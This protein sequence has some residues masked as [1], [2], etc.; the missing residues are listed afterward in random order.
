[1]TKPAREL[2][3]NR[4]PDLLVYLGIERHYLTGKH[5]PCPACGG[6]DRFRFDDKDG[7]GTYF[8]SHCGSGDGF[9]LLGLVKGWSFKQAATEVEQIV[10][11]IRATIPIHQPAQ[12]DMKEACRRIWSE[13]TPVVDS[14]PVSRYLRLRTGL[15]EVPPCIRYHPTLLYRHDDG[16]I[17]RHPAMVAKVTD[18]DGKGTAI[19]R[20]YLTSAGHKADL[21][22]VKKVLGNLPPGAAIQLFPPAE[23]LGIA[24]GIETALAASR[25]F[26]VPVWAAISAGGLERWTPPESTQ[27]VMVFGDND[28]N[29]TGQAAAFALA[30]RLTA[31]GISTEV[32]V[33]TTQGSDWCDHEL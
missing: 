3:R 30:K 10:G 20:T 26:G 15:Y 1:M 9:A 33:P 25:R 24:E 18:A 12:A 32:H 19:H 16:H 17:S 29:H 22:V 21:P 5:A 11:K 13:S 31:V 2:A 14:D 4:W 8:C 28:E 27:H 23:C 7:R 6:K